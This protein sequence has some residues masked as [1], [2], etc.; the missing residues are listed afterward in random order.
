MK[1]KVLFFSNGNIAVFDGDEQVP[2]LQQKAVPILFAEFVESKG[3]NPEDFI[4]EFPAGK[5][6]LFKA[7]HGWN[8]R[9]ND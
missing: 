3:Y 9:F 7:K 1:F 4:L 2:E 8:W 5:A 6:T